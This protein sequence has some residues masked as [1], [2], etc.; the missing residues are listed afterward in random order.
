M[1]GG[2]GLAHDALEFSVHGGEVFG[3]AFD[4]GFAFFPESDGGALFGF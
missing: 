1:D 2:E 3:H 4:L